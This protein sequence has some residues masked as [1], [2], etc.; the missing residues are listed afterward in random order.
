MR[1]LIDGNFQVAGT[2][3]WI[4]GSTGYMEITV[5]TVKAMS[6]RNEKLS[7]G[8]YANVPSDTSVPGARYFAATGI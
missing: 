8:L 5:E 3:R 4:I 1:R 2:V 6:N 7:D